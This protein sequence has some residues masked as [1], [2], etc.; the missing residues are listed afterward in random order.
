[1]IGG[2]ISSIRHRRPKASLNPSSWQSGGACLFGGIDRG[3]RRQGSQRPGGTS[4][5][6]LSAQAFGGQTL[7]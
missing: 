5:P 4:L 1:M 3:A 2:G 6:D 7:L